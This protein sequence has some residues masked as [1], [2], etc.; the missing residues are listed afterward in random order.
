MRKKKEQDG[1]VILSAVKNQNNYFYEN[2]QNREFVTIYDKKLGLYPKKLFLEGKDK[3]VSITL[4]DSSGIQVKSNENIS[5]TADGQIYFKGEK[6]SVT[7]PLEISCRTRESNIE[8]C[9]DIN[10]YSPVSVNLAEEE[11]AERMPDDAKY[12]EQDETVESWRVSFSAIS[13]I[14][15]V[16]LAQM[17]GNDA[18]TGMFTC[19]SIPKMAQG[20][21]TVAMAEVMGGIKESE[22]SFPKT[23]CSMQNDMVKGGCALLED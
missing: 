3:N 2:T 15:A 5:F 19:G 10:L 4:D 14:P 21:T 20:Q 18:V 13:A 16:D 9:R 6:V 1:Q 12:K 8:L 22:C 7:A 17:E 23:F 11:G